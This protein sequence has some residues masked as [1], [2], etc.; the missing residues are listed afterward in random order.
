MTQLRFEPVSQKSD[1][2]HGNNAYIALDYSL[3]SHSNVQR[4]FILLFTDKR[5]LYN[6][7][8]WLPIPHL[9]RQRRPLYPRGVSPG[10]N[11]TGSSAQADSTCL[12]AKP[13]KFFGK[14]RHGQRDKFIQKLSRS[15]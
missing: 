2:Q 11:Q 9:L 14:L 13:H 8:H 4:T 12:P 15:F 10:V 1:R 6:Q 7:G 3:F 5:S